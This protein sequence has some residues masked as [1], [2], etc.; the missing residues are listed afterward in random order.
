MKKEKMYTWL[1]LLI[2]WQLLAMYIDNTVLIPFPIDVLLRILENFQEA[3]FYSAI[4][5]TL[6]RVF[7]AVSLSF[8]VAICCSI[9]SNRFSKFRL[10]F[11]PIQI[12]TKSI[13]TI[14]YIII[15]LIF[16]GSESSVSI[17]CFL[18]LFPIFYNNFLFSMDSEPQELKDVEK[19][20]PESFWETTK[21]KTIPM[22]YP[23][24]LS[25][26]KIAFGLGI[27]V[28]VMAEILGQVKIGIGKELYLSRIYLDIESLFAWT[29]IIILLCFIIDWCFDQFINKNKI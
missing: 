5:M 7:V 1:M 14:S 28:S 17:I 10:F 22:L 23:S 3:S 4:G 27:K 2:L 15:V 12:L 19:I 18:I 6:I 25:S 21:S 16:F 9:L 24:I 8:L 13:P 11:D 26:C 20:Y 29:I